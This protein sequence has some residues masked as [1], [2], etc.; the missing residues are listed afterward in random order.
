MRA[1]PVTVYATAAT[2]DILRKHIFNW[3][4]WPDFTA[5]P[6]TATP[7]LRYQVLDAGSSVL[8]NDRKVTAIPANH[9]VPAVGYHLDSGTSSLVFSGDTTCNGLLWDYLNGVENLR[10]LIIETAFPDEERDLAIASKHLCPTMLADELQLLRRPAQILITHLKPGAA[11]IT[12]QEVHE[13]AGRYRPR[14]L[15]H[16]EIIVF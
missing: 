5:I 15:S 12:M 11:A 9:V 4:I 16:G 7:Y 13:R 2:V 1:E 10:Y 14:M 8:L 6:S 3:L